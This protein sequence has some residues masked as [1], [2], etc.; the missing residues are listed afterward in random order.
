MKRLVLFVTIACLVAPARAQLNSGPMMPTQPTLGAGVPNALANPPNANG[1]VTLLSG[2][3]AQGN[4]LV[5]SANGIQD[6]GTTLRPL[7]RIGTATLRGDRGDHRFKPSQS[8]H[9]FRRHLQLED[10]LRRK[11]RRIDRRHDGD[12]ELV[13]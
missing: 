10:R 8:R 5:W 3:A 1:G 12:A 6:L 2:P 7:A 4:C 11:M 9:R 13:Q